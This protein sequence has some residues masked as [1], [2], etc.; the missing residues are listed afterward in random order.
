MINE[1]NLD[2]FAV[3]VSI[4]ALLVGP[5]LAPILGGYTLIMFGWFA[6]VLIGVYR[7][8]AG[9]RMGTI[10][11]VL[12]FFLVTMGT[13]ATAAELLAPYIGGKTNA[14]L[15]PVAVLIPAI[16]DDW[17]AVAKWAWRLVAARFERRAEGGQ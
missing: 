17:I 9:S 14:L 16:G 11:F 4:A 12:L 15:F 8:D 10:V 3:A 7:R 6:G 1:P 13:A 5:K 2:P